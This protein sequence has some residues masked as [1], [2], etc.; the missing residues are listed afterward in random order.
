MTSPFFFSLIPAFWLVSFLWLAFGPRLKK[1]SLYFTRGESSY[2]R[3]PRIDWLNALGRTI[4]HLSEESERLARL[5]ERMVSW[6][7]SRES[8][9]S[10]SQIRK[11]QVQ[12]DDHPRFVLSDRL[13]QAKVWTLIISS[14]KSDV[15]SNHRHQRELRSLSVIP[16]EIILE[17]WARQNKGTPEG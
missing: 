13:H 16:E 6:S 11:D 7:V 14:L 10:N 1:W 3:K 5:G 17:T 15:N 8:Q 4:W 12:S 9:I 2:T